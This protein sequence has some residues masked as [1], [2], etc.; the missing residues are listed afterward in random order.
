MLNRGVNGERSDQIRARFERDVLEERGRTGPFSVVIIAGVNDIYQGR[1]AD[2]VIREL[3]TMYD[4]AR[5]AAIPLVAGSILPFNTATPDHNTRM[6]S[7]NEWIRGYASRTA[8][9]LYCDTRAAV[10]A[11]DA[12]DRLLSSPDDLHPSPE[13][14][15]LMAIALEPLV[16]RALAIGVGKA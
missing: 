10:A 15:R 16:K 11:P 5:A 2:A 9:V 13:G 14:Y 1:G 7:V 8:G 12:P 4:L 6:R 3:E